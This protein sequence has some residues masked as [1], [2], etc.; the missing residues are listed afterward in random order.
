MVMITV[1]DDRSTYFVG[2]PH[3]LNLQAFIYLFLLKT[4]HMYTSTYNIVTVFMLLIA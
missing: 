3:F 2:K 4:S 1:T